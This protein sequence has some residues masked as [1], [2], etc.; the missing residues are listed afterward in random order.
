[1]IALR[2]ALAVA[3]LITFAALSVTADPKGPHGGYE[4]LV[5][6]LWLLLVPLVITIAGIIREAYWARW[7]GLAAGVA[8]L[9]W[10]VAVLLGPRYGFPVG[11]PTLALGAALLLLST[12]LGRSMFERYEARA[13]ATAWS[14]RRMTLVRWTI[15]FNIA[16]VLALYLFVA[17]YEY[18]IDWHLV[19]PAS[20][21][22]GLLS[23]VVLLAH[24]RTIGLLLVALCCVLFVPAGGYFVWQEASYTGEAILFA[25]V[26]LPGVLSGWATL[27]AFSGAIWRYLRFG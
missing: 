10:A 3:A 22:I 21:L 24:Q 2:K 6:A 8:V 16:S 14:T 25:V 9:P 5:V 1:M 18:R 11:R 19:I 4:K 12:L 15:V 13:R 17:V 20:L 23:G 7:L 26:F 27:L